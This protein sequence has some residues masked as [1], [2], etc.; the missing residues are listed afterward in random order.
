MSTVLTS[1][2]YFSLPRLPRRNNSRPHAAPTHTV[3]DSGAA[4]PTQL[5]FF[6]KRPWDDPSLLGVWDHPRTPSY[7]DVSWKKSGEKWKTQG[8]LQR[9]IEG[10]IQGIIEVQRKI[11]GK[12][13][14]DAGPE[15]V[16]GSSFSLAWIG[17]VTTP[18]G[19]RAAEVPMLSGRLLP[20]VPP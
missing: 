14:R 9:K 3:L 17:C 7:K 8:K 5:L 1:R 4:V 13:A 10:K 18:L 12:I 15:L 2:V 16:L 11:Q 19:R 20:P 6:F